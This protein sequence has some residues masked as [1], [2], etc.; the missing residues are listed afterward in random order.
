MLFLMNDTVLEV[1]MRK[2][3]PPA[4]RARFQALTLPFV[5]NL[6]REMFAEQPLI[7]QERSERVLRLAALILSKAP[8]VNAALFQAPRAGCAPGEVAAELTEV[9]LPV[10]GALY[11]RQRQAALTPVAVDREVWRRMAA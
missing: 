9:S 5:M 11:E 7:H 10:L 8:D 6:G 2:L 1:D 4:Q 3:V